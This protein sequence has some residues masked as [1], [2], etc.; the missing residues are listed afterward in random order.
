MSNPS[1]SNIDRWLFELREGNLSP[2]QV[3]QLTIF[4][5]N[6]PE[7]DIDKDAWELAVVKKED[8]EYPKKSEYYRRRPIGL[9]MA[10]GFTSISIFVAIGINLISSTELALQ[11]DVIAQRNSLGQNAKSTT[12]S[13][14]SI[15]S[16]TSN[17]YNGLLA[18]NQLSSTN[19]VSRLGIVRN[20]F[21][22]GMQ[23]LIGSSVANTEV[24]SS[25]LSAPIHNSVEALKLRVA[26][27][28]HYVGSQKTTESE[29]ARHGAKERKT[30]TFMQRMMRK[31]KKMMDQP[32]ALR[33]MRDP[34]FMV[35]GI[36]A[37]DANFS[38]T[39][40]L[41]VT[42]IQSMTRYQWAQHA[43]EQWINQLGFD[44]Y[45]YGLR[46]GVGLQVTNGYYHKGQIVN[47][48][49]AL[50]YSPKIAITK[51]ILF[52]PALRFK[53]GSKMLNAEKID[54]LGTAEFD[55]QNTNEFYPNGS[56]PNGKQLWYRDLGLSMML[57][58]KW[59]YVG[60]QGD[61]LLRH[62]D[63]IYS[64]ENASERRVGYHFVATIGTDYLSQKENFALSPYVLYQ[65][66]ENLKEAW[67]GLN[68]RISWL[69]V[70]GSISNNLDGVA[71]LGVKFKRFAFSCQADYTTSQM[72]N[73]KLLSY[74]VNLKVITFNPNRKQKLINF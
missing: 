50:T 54:G 32:V 58:T 70:G 7:F 24:H 12:I 2:E 13:T 51:N 48:N 14:P 3:Q 10:A 71:S 57:N 69:T 59:F 11:E 67:L 5:L 74:Q 62:Y 43:N 18:E 45:I 36:S 73:K 61:N 49:V 1:F 17:N 46:G 35:P 27:E 68:A 9:Y 52:E 41:P 20:V 29:D 37:L 19:E 42:R 66:S 39:G 65:E 22:L 30:S 38:G 53:M 26:K 25:S 40:S 60:V 6:H 31:F 23:D 28:V 47:T 64:G 4:L 56:L 72:L 63:N 15:V 21:D 34:N 55:R 16:T 44:S 8:F 33:N